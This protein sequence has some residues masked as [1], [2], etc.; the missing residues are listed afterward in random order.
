MVRCRM[1]SKNFDEEDVERY[2]S[3]KIGYERY[4]EITNEYSRICDS[5]ILSFYYPFI[6]EDSTDNLKQ[7][8]EGKQ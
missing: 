2:I 6:D 7:E 1:C 8:S 4:K 5:C 3:S